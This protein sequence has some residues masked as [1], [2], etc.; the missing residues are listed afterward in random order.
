MSE[1]EPDKPVPPGEYLLA[2]V[3]FARRTSKGGNDYLR[4]RFTVCSGPLKGRGFFTP[5]SL[6]TSNPGCKRR[7]EVW[8]EQVGCDEEIDLDSDRAI[9][10]HFKGAPFK[11]EVQTKQRGQYTN[12]DLGRLIYLRQYTPQ[13]MVNIA[14]WKQEWSTRDWSGQD[15]GDPGPTG[16]DAPP[17]P[18][19]E[20]Q[21]SEGSNFA[22]D[23]DSDD[24]PF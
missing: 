9:N 1:R 15:P 8:M 19:S 5:W 11:A 17:T 14:T 24:I 22:D 18:E 12:T 7:W 6:D 13:D 4:C 3:W 2:L 10:Q 20:P 16:D 23:G 21:W